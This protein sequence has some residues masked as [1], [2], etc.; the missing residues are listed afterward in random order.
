MRIAATSDD[1]KNIRLATARAALYDP[2]F[3]NPDNAMIGAWAEAIKPHALE[4][5]DVLD[6]VTNHYRDHDRTLM[7]ADVIRRARQLRRD[8]QLREAS[9][10]RVA[11]L[12]S[13]P[14]NPAL[15][16]LPIPTDGRPV[17]AAYQVNNAIDRTCPHCAAPPDHY[18]RNQ[19][20][21]QT[22]KIPCLRRMKDDPA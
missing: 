9:S 17:D 16:G 15:G 19:L 6:A 20:T 10:D 22:S 4:T 3:S 7:V 18:C 13:A 12:P 5:D 8:R 11:S 14:P 1:I 21:K 2:K